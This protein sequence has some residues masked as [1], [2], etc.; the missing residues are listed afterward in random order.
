MEREVIALDE[1]ETTPPPTSWWD[2]CSCFASPDGGDDADGGGGIDLAVG[3]GYGAE[4]DGAISAT[5][6]DEWLGEILKGGTSFKSASSVND[7]LLGPASRTMTGTIK[8]NGV[9]KATA[10]SLSL[11]P[12]EHPNARKALAKHADTRAG[13][14]DDEAVKAKQKQRIQAMRAAEAAGED[15]AAQRAAL[16]PAV[17]VAFLE[18]ALPAEGSGPRKSYAQMLATLPD[19]WSSATRADFPASLEAAGG[20]EL[21]KAAKRAMR[22]LH[23]DKLGAQAPQAPLSERMMAE[24]LFMAIRDAQPNA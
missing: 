15:E 8:A 24:R 23:P 22:V 17:K 12:I 5:P 14:A 18:W 6:A 7:A 11:T 16:E 13:Y 4:R 10:I 21:R 19:V 9:R 2:C 20:A 1:T 3:T